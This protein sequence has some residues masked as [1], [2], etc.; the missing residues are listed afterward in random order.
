MGNNLRKKIFKIIGIVIGGIILLF[1]GIFIYGYFNEPIAIYDIKEF[2]EKDKAILENKMSK[3]E[4][5]EDIDYIINIMESTHPIFLE[6]V[7]KEYHIAKDELLRAKDKNMTVGELQNKISR[8]LSSVED[9]HTRLWWK[10]D[11]FLK[12]DW[13]Y[14][15]GKLYLIDDSGKLTNKAV[16]KIENIKIEDIVK[17]IKEV[18]PA[19]NHIA[20]QKNIERYA[21]GKL[22]LESIGVNFNSNINIFL[23]VDEKE[24]IME[25]KLTREFNEQYSSSSIYSEIL[26]GNIAYIRL[27]TCEVNS[28]L[29]TVIKEIENYKKME[30]EDYIINVI[31]NQ[32]GNSEAC[33]LILQALNIEPG[34]YGG[35]IR[36]SPLAQEQR[37]YLRKNGNITYKSNNEVK[38]NENI[39]LYIL[40]N[41]NTFSS[42]QMLAVWV[43][44]GNLGKIIG[45][46]SSNM[47]SSFGDVL[48]YQLKNSKL[49]G[50][51]SHKKWIRPDIDKDRE[52]I[53]MPDIY[54][55]YEEDVLEKVLNQVK[56][57]KSSKIS[58]ILNE[59]FIHN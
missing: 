51:I 28:E 2:K 45:R 21:K 18:F 33:E 7:P 49:L 12:I 57:T 38:K 26:D 3:E 19:E 25:G 48:F 9:G 42:A 14:K 34:S 52:K 29:E 16:T 36:F 40:T 8:Y 47:P 41:E 32:G 23:E 56:R 5:S 53:L 59:K 30:I 39:N 44:D 17:R 4:V 11:I 55:E 20:E 1:G 22:L 58:N 37:G 13:K 24:E 46:P 31:D 10:E 50:Q 35:V 27:G 43:R 6:E 54:V 15:D